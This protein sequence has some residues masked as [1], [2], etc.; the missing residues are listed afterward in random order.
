VKPTF[1]KSQDTS[2]SV[3]N[4]RGEIEKILRRYGA[5]GIS[6]Q[7][8]FDERNQPE[9]VTVSFI[10]PD[11]VG[12][13]RK[14]PVSL[15]INV[16]RVYDG[17]YGQPTK[18]LTPKNEAERHAPPYNGAWHRKVFNPARYDPRTMPQAERVAWRNLVLWIDAALSAAAVGLQTITEAFYAHT[19]VQLEGG[20]Q[21][22]LADYIERMQGQ[23]APGIRALLSAPAEVEN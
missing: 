5:S 2:V 3:A 1:V 10:V 8:T 16:K 22:R 7:Q 21:A 12:S 9:A 6:V 13:E 19:V 4:S 15:P 17:L 14:V 11:K 20:G 23:L 18:T